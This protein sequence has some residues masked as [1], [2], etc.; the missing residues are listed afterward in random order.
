MYLFS[1]SL[2]KFKDKFVRNTDL[3]HSEE[4]AILE[5]TG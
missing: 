1:N 2:T 3:P 4:P 5:R